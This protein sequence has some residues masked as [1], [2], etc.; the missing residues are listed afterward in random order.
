VLSRSVTR[1]TLAYRDENGAWQEKWDAREAGGLP[2]AVRFELAVGTL[3]RTAPAVIIAL[4]VGTKA[5]RP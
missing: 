1:F 5:Q 4:P 3:A 2:T